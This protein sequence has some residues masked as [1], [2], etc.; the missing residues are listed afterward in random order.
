MEASKR[1]FTPIS[2]HKS[3]FSIPCI[4]VLNLKLVSTSEKVEYFAFQF[5]KFN[6][7]KSF[8]AATVFTSTSG[9]KK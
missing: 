2:R 7:D 1:G 8:I 4:V 3:D 5:V 6:S 9:P